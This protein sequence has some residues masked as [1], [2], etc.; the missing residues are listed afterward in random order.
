WTRVNA[1]H[2]DEYVGISIDK[3]QSFRNYLNTH[4]FSRKPFK[5]VNLIN[6]DGPDAEKTASD[7]AK[8][9]KSKGLDLIVLG[10]GETGH[11]AFND[12]PDARF[13]EPK[14]AKVIELGE[15][16]RMQQV[17][18]GCFK[19]IDEVPKQAITVTIPAFVSASCLHCVVPGP[20]KS[21]AV[22]ATLEGPVSE[23]C[24]AS[25]LRNHPN[26]HL[27]LDNDSAALLSKRNPEA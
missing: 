7:Y 12:P 23:A 18:D 16:S 4:I 25:V 3:P 27:Y 11:I 21:K 8:L 14:L 10:I 9:L 2:M 26:A 22:K 13:D 6:A 24:P 19:T 1:F 5:S 20:T 15:V 17:H